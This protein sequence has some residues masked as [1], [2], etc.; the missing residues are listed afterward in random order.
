[1]KSFPAPVFFA[2]VALAVVP[3][4][5]RSQ[6]EPAS[7]PPAS[8]KPAA[9]TSAQIQQ[10]VEKVRPSLVRIR[11]VEGVP[12][13]G[14][15]GKSESFGSGVIISPEG[16]V[17]TNHH[18]A[19]NARWLSVTLASKEE[20]EAKLVGTDPLADIA[21]IKLA[22]SPSGGAYP[23]ASWGDSSGLKVGDPVLAMGSPLAFSQSVTS[24]IVSNNEL[25]LPAQFE[26]GMTLEGE[27][28]GSIV[29]WIGHDAQI[30]PGN[31]GGPLISLTGEVIGINEIGVGLAGAIPGNI[32]RAVAEQ[33]IAQGHVSRAYTGLELQPRLRRDGSAA[34]AP[35]V[36]VGGVL[37]G[38]P[39][40][41]AGLKP[42]DLLIRAAGVT[43][44]AR[45]PEQLPLL[46]W[47]L[48]LLPVGKAASFEV[49]RGGKPIKVD[50]I[51]A[52][53]EP[54]E[55]RA[56]E[57]K[58][59]GMTCS[60]LTRTAAREKRIDS[61]EGAMVTTLATGGPSAEAQPPLR[62]EDVILSV[63]GKK[64]KNV[65]ALKALTDSLPRT[66]DG[67][68]APTLVEFR[69]DGQ[70]LATVVSV[71]RQSE[72][73]ASLE[74]A[75]AWLPVEVQVLTPSLARA[76]GL[77]GGTRGVRVTQLYSEVAP[78]TAAQFRVGDVITRMD[79]LPVDADQPEQADVFYAMVRQYRIGSP[80]EVTLFRDNKP[81]TLKIATVRAPKQERE[82][83]RHT[84]ETFGVTFRSVGYKDRADRDAAPGE[85]GALVVDVT[86]G[87]W[88]ALAGVRP[89]DII[90]AIDGT[91]VSGMESAAARLRALDA[92]RPRS[93]TLFISRGVH[94]Q[95]VEVQ[96]DYAMTTPPVAAG[97]AA[98][99]PAAT[100]ARP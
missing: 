59:W 13:N 86:K 92:A 97:S 38:S 43:L 2:L 9:P 65:A 36:L 48:S 6:S 78:Q 27:D 30:F 93:V 41:A 80:A 91:P 11:V 22:A 82:L 35:G 51:P 81:L 84:N 37:P 89:G 5:A 68:G 75:K 29:R 56:V 98:V 20:V 64:V 67:E 42:G 32:A 18:V 60:D 77:P 4:A 96:T 54:A 83:S 8:A 12:E 23:A 69:R 62:E 21:V 79:G 19:G 70:R 7:P 57:V 15:E 50:I 14:R 100:A 85:R 40:A 55:A 74:V 34:D 76:L 87:G 66:S 88:A 63:G 95:Y 25:I 24:G 45:Y 44:S 72:D 46:N 49:V 90:R 61:T 39:A 28:V 31:S 26:G 58:G 1:M 47:Q 17:V 53:R 94:T 3:V 52:R 33:I 10:I 71:G 99:S 73:D 16:Y